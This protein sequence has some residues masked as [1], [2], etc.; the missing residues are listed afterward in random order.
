MQGRHIHNLLAIVLTLSGLSL[1]AYAYDTLSQPPERV[2]PP[3]A[4][5]TP[6]TGKSVADASMKAPPLAPLQSFAQITARPLFSATRRPPVPR[7]VQKP[8]PIIASAPTPVKIETGR[9]V[10][11]GIVI[12]ENTKA[13]LLRKG[14]KGALMRVGIGQKLDGWTVEDIVAGSVKLRQGDVVDLVLL[15][16]NIISQTEMRRLK[17]LKRRPDRKKKVV[18]I[19]RQRRNASQRLL[20]FKRLKRS[21]RAIAPRRAVMGGRAVPRRR[22]TTAP[23][24]KVK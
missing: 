22:L 17:R 6:L 16:D 7:K 14:S 2:T 12:D 18:R 19:N 13:A 10:V 21:K 3:T 23:P 20:K 8:K 5:T 15:R 9:Y 1:G 4:V 11:M 24:V